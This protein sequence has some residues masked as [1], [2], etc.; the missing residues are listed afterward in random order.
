MSEYNNFRRRAVSVLI[1]GSLLLAGLTA[2]GK[3]SDSSSSTSAPGSGTTS[4]GVSSSVPPDLST[5]GGSASSVPPQEPPQQIYDFSQPAP[6]SSPVDD[7]YFADAVFI[8]DSR[9]ES[10]MMFSGLTAGDGLTSV[11]MNSYRMFDTP[12]IEQNGTE[13]T[14]FDAL[15]L[16]H[17]GKIYFSLGVNEMG[18]PNDDL[19]QDN[20]SR[21][22][23]CFRVLEPSAVIYLEN[24]IPLNEGIIK[25]NGGSEYLRNDHLRLLNEELAQLA[26]KKQVILLDAYSLFADENGSLPDDASNDGI[27]LKPEQ[28][29]KL[30]AYIR[31]HTV[32][33]AAAYPG[34]MPAGDPTAMPGPVG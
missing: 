31:A 17:Y 32:D 7:S 29:Q 3:N 22:I 2:C 5:P 8:G 18:Y 10:F 30:L 9:M 26:E 14:V 33:P 16:K 19:Y 1:A 21:A 28:S 13:L 24:L 23:E 11:G 20:I 27:H 15:N 6:E 4:S 12:Y 25:A 34:G